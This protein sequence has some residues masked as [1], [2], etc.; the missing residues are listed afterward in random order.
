MMEK[1]LDLPV[2]VSQHGPDMDRMMVLV[3][4][5]MGLLAAGWTVFFFYVLW[6]FRATRNRR[7]DHAGVQGHASTWLEV[8]VVSFEAVLLVGF[9]I[10]LWGKAVDDFPPVEE[11]TVVRVVAEQFGWWFIYPG[12]DGKFGRQDLSLVT[13][14]N[15]FGFDPEDPATGDNIQVLNEM[16]V[17]VNRPVILNCSSK[18]VIH[19]FKVLPMRVNQQCIPGLNI[20]IHFV[21]VKEG[22]YQVICAQLCGNG[23]AKM[24]QGVLTVLP[25]DEYE[26]WFG[27]QVAGEGAATSFE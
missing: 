9:A 18:D 23:H 16:R 4:W 12:P 26:A 27:S 3:H 6:R 8:G 17:P 7:A 15:P 25:E 13:S 11:S 14:E 5:L 19:T 20:P 21:P 10:P 1:L 24:A 22:R 2:V